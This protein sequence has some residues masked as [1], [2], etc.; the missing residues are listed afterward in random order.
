MKRNENSKGDIELVKWKEE[1]IIKQPIEQVWRLF[2]DENA[3]ILYPKLEDHV[4]IENE[5]DE[6]GAK[7]AQSYMEGDQLQTY[8]VETI[9]FEDK[10]TRKIRHTRFSMNGMFQI[11]Y[12]FTLDKKPDGQTLFTYEGTQKGMTLTGKAMMMAG[13]RK[14]RQETVRDFVQRV[15][16]TAKKFAAE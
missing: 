10:P 14:R 5:N 6:T 7:H 1:I 15:E 2:S 4:L 3:K 8:I 9:R 13:S 12:I 11:D 16:M